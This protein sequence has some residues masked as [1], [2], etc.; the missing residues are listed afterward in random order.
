MNKGL[1]VESKHHP[2][3]GE[4]LFNMERAYKNAKVGLV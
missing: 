2:D 4:K 1:T 3:G